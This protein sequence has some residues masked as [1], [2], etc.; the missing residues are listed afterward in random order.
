MRSEVQETHAENIG[1][2]ENRLARLRSLAPQCAGAYRRKQAYVAPRGQT[3]ESSTKEGAIHQEYEGSSRR[4]PSNSPQP[5]VFNRHPSSSEMP[6]MPKV[7]RVLRKRAHTNEKVERPSTRNGRAL[8]KRRAALPPGANSPRSVSDPTQEVVGFP[9]AGQEIPEDIGVAPSPARTV[10]APKRAGILCLTI[11]E[12]GKS[13][14]EI[15]VVLTPPG[16]AQHR[17]LPT[18]HLHPAGRRGHS[19]RAHRSKCRDSPPL[20]RAHRHGLAR[21]L[22]SRVGTSG[23]RRSGDAE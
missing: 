20:P 11:G 21:Q 18:P 17:S 12:K 8:W 13:D 15:R 4:D 19:G 23:E 6:R 9:A 16:R 3:P 5:R 22:P 10:G 1:K 2:W 7:R 14:L